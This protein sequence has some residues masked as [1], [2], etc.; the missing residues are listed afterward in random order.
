[1]FFNLFQELFGKEARKNR[2]LAASA[3]ITAWPPERE[4]MPGCS[5]HGRRRRIFK[6]L[7]RWWRRGRG[8]SR[9]GGRQ[10]LPPGRVE[11]RRSG[12]K[13]WI[14]ELPDLALKAIRAWETSGQSQ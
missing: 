12:K 11:G 7:P 2:H 10:R 13:R 3:A 14:A 5:P 1:M 8:R 6:S 4:M 9:T